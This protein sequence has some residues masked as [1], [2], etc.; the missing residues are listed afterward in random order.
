MDPPEWHKWITVRLG[1]G[2]VQTRMLPIDFWGDLKKNYE[3]NNRDY[4]GWYKG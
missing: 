1:T 3:A 2:G 4:H